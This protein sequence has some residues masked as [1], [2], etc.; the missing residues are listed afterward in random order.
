MAFLPHTF[1]QNPSALTYKYKYQY[2]HHCHCYKTDNN[3]KS[4]TLLYLAEGFKERQFTLSPRPAKGHRLNSWSCLNV[5]QKE[6]EGQEVILS[7]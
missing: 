5:F 6:V 1:F 2:Y 4:K 7:D 3:N